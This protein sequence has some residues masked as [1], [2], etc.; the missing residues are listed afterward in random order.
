MHS[1]NGHV[2]IASKVQDARLIPESRDAFLFMSSFKQSISMQPWPVCAVPRASFMLTF[3]CAQ[4]RKDYREGNGLP[5]PPDLPTPEM[6]AGQGR[7]FPPSVVIATLSCGPHP[8][9]LQETEARGAGVTCWDSM[10][11]LQS[12]LISTLCSMASH[13]AAGR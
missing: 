3:T 13:V 7:E 4:D 6:V 9:G 1:L 5:G 10:V 8:A 2:A 12:Q 11:P